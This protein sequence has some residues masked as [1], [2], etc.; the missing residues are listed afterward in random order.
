MLG[1]IALEQARGEPFRA[2]GP[3]AGRR[4]ELTRRQL[5]PAALLLRAL[6]RHVS[7]GEAERLTRAAIEMGGMAFL[8]SLLGDLD[9]ATVG[10]IATE[11]RA[12]LGRFFN[13]EGDVAI[14]EAE[15]SFTVRRCLFVELAPRIGA[16]ALMPAFCEVDR[17]FFDS[18]LT[19]LRLSRTGTLA[20]GGGRCDFHF[21]WAEP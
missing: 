9:P 14:G 21:R 4:E 8:G 12:R 1:R 13:A 16:A 3:S 2:L 20:G 10:D 18:G 15:A 6:R 17:T 11:V 7:I 5:G 19:P